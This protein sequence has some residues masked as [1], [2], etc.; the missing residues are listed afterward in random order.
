[1]SIDAARPAVL[2]LA[3]PTAAGKTATAI[4]LALELDGEIISADARQVYRH[5]D[6]GTAKPTAEQLAAIPH[7]VIDICEPEERYSAAR[8]L[9]DAGAALADIHARGKQAIVTGGTGLYFRALREG[10]FPAPD[11]AP[12]TRDEVDVMWAAGG[13]DALTR[14]LNQQD[15]R[16]LDAID[17]RNPARLRRAV[18]FHLQTGR[19]LEESRRADPG[20]GLDYGFF[21]V[22]LAVPRPQLYERITHRVDHLLAAGWLEET[23]SLAERYDFDW[24]AFN[25]VGYRELYSVVQHKVTL[26]DAREQII[27]RTRNYAKRQLTWFTRQGQWLWISAGSGVTSKIAL[28]L[29]NSCRS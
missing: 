14:Y 25:A 22:A 4:D 21:A 2:L 18:E 15:P 23:R 28:A 20:R 11:I 1:M 12:E 8:F 6:I 17:Q 13:R 9:N 24:P 16:T 27:Q 10:L 26:S 29:A 3:G 7:H 5:L 19:S